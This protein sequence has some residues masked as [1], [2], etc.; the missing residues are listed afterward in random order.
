MLSLAS[1]RLSFTSVYPKLTNI[2]YFD[3]L[4][5][6]NK[7]L[8]NFIVYFKLPIF[9]NVYPINIWRFCSNIFE[10]LPNIYYTYY[11]LL[12]IYFNAYVYKPINI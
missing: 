5:C 3:I 8:Y 6:F 2:N 1:Y 11:K 7:L 4:L 10:T 9:N 12:F